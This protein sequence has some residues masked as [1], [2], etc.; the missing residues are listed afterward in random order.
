M[1]S[2]IGTRL[3]GGTVHSALARWKLLSLVLLLCTLGCGSPAKN[4]IVR[5]IEQ[6]CQEYA[7]K[8]DCVIVIEDITRFK[9]DRMY[10]FGAMS[11]P[12]DIE[13]TTGFDCNCRFVADDHNRLMFTYKDRVIHMEDFKTY[14]DESLQFRDLVWDSGQ[15]PVYTPSTAKFYVVK[16]RRTGRAG[17]FYDLYTVP[18]NER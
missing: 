4:R 3:T 2:V 8:G 5:D 11:F 14:T 16:R 17:V 18:L 6:N 10:V 13:E 1:P 9:W 15:E 12:E 7:E